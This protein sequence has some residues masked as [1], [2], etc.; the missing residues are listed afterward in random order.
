MTVTA[1]SRRVNVNVH[2]A[3]LTGPPASRYLRRV[4]PM[5]RRTRAI[6]LCAGLAGW[7]VGASAETGYD[8]WLP[9]QGVASHVCTLD[10]RDVD[11]AL[12]IR[13]EAGGEA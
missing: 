10:K 11:V 8:L 7:P 4:S 6:V 3:G 2:V 5:S 12:T 9:A 1:A 13:A